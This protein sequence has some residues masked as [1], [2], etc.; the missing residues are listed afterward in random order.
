V[1][2]QLLRKNIS[3]PTVRNKHDAR[4][5]RIVGFL[6]DYNQTSFATCGFRRFAGCSNRLPHSSRTCVAAPPWRGI[7]V[8]SGSDQELATLESQLPKLAALGAN[9]LIVG[10]GYRFD[11]QSH[12]ELR[13][14]QFITKASG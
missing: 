7:H 11:F 3:S 12:P 1:Q 4:E 14:A 2:A 13:A 5:L 10:V 6:P 9:V 8:N